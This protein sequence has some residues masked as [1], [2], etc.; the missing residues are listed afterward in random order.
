MLIGISCTSQ[1]DIVD[2]IFFDSKATTSKLKV[3]SAY[4]G[5][6]I[7]YIYQSTDNGYIKGEVHGLIAASSDIS[8]TQR[9]Y[10]G[11]YINT[12]ATLSGIGSASDNTYLIYE[13]QGAGSYAA[14]ACLNFETNEYSDWFLPTIDELQILYNNRDAIGGF[15]TYPYW[16]STEVNT[17]SANG[18]NFAD[19]TTH[20]YYK[21]GYGNVRPIRYF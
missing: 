21:N 4:Q 1:S 5:G 3:G 19:G 9:W 15:S 8:S 14:N 13:Q 6:K 2:E 17:Q 10:N 7:A 20:S 18:L 16:S 11:S 12:Y